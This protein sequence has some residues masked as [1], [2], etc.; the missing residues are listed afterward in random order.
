MGTQGGHHEVIQGGHHE[1][2][3]G[4]HG[5]PPLP[6]QA[7]LNKFSHPYLEASPINIE[8]RV[9]PHSLRSG[10]GDAYS[11]STMTRPT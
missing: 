11:A 6:E 8:S 9:E 3:Q 4:G 2:I 5:G 1:V 7:C 10:A